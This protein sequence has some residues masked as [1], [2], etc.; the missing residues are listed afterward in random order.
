MQTLAM[1]KQIG[2]VPGGLDG[3]Q[4]RVSP[5]RTG[6]CGPSRGARP[7]PCGH[8]WS[9]CGHGNRGSS[10]ACEYSADRCASCFVPFRC[11]EQLRKYIARSLRVKE[12]TQER[13]E[14]GDKGAGRGLQA[15]GVGARGRGARLARDGGHMTARRGSGGGGAGGGGEQARRGG[16]RRGGAQRGTVDSH[17]DRS[18]FAGASRQR[19]YTQR[20]GGCEE[21][22]AAGLVERAVGWIAGR[23]DRPQRNGR[24][25]S[26]R[27]TLKNIGV[28][29]ENR[30]ED[31]ENRGNS[32]DGES[33]SIGSLWKMLK[34]SFSF[35]RRCGNPHEDS[36]VKMHF[37]KI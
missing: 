29:I 24:S 10:P 33:F 9:T 20:E 4:S 1:G 3:L 31:A 22:R 36:F 18:R 14:P 26:P 11:S 30:A 25:L 17:G 12:N 13:K 7:E 21:R 8:P 16:G 28:S 27:P 34:T 19:R 2:D 32:S 35:E 23:L 37:A 6:A 15:A 5:T